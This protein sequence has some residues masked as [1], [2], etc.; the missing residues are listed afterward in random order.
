MRLYDASDK[1]FCF[2]NFSHNAALLL[3]VELQ[4]S[5]SFCLVERL[6]TY[7]VKIDHGPRKEL[8]TREQ[9]IIEEF[10]HPS[11]TAGIMRAKQ[12]ESARKQ[13]QKPK[14]ESKK[15]LELTYSQSQS[16]IIE[17]SESPPR[18]DESEHTSTKNENQSTLPTIVTNKRR[19]MRIIEDDDE[20]N[21]SESTTSTQSRKRPAGAEPA[22]APSRKRCK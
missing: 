22:D 13:Y 5:D 21:E 6:Y 3:Q 15:P 1:I 11:D 7:V 10:Y 17:L 14:S 18:S 8:V 2:K 20:D 4:D 9:A 12:L 19:R 16:D